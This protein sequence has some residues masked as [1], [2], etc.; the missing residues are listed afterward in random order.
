MSR[1][2][3]PDQS[4]AHPVHS[5][6]TQ[7]PRVSSPHP[8]VVLAKHFFNFLAVAWLIFLIPLLVQTHSSPPF[9]AASLTHRL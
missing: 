5:H 7:R 2:C 9:Q 8:G 3:F 1:A 6:T 4:P